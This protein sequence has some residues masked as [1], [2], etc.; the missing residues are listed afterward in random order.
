M[1]T[2]FFCFAIANTRTGIEKKQ[3]VLGA[4]VVRLP[5]L[6]WVFFCIFNWAWLGPS[7][8]DLAGCLGHKSHLI[9][10]QIKQK[11]E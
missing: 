11:C 7:W 4:K 2:S 5:R 10:E 6:G 3:I 9:S 8:L 1:Q